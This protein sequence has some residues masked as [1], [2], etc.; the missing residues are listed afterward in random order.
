LR[1]LE[2]AMETPHDVA[3]VVAAL[4]AE[5]MNRYFSVRGDPRRAITDEELAAADARFAAA[6]LRGQRSRP[7]AYALL[8]PLWTPTQVA[9]HL[10]L[11]RVT[12]NNWRQKGKLLAL[13]QD[14]RGYRYPAFQF[15]TVPGEGEDGVIE[16]FTDVL[17]A[18]PTMSNWHKGMFFLEPSPA[19]GGRT[20]IDILPKEGRSGLRR[21]LDWAAAYGEMGT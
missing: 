21:V 9:R 10:G 16:G 7:E 12:V 13:R 18:L 2:S 19:L 11:S 1:V 14:E 15:A 8:G 6:R 5:R 17:R 3:N 20:P 4:D